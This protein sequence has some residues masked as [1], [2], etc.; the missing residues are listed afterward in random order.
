M[1][2]LAQTQLG[3]SPTTIGLLSQLGLRGTHDILWPS[4]PDTS[5]SASLVAGLGL[6]ERERLIDN[7]MDWAS[8]LESPDLEGRLPRECWIAYL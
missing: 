8:K 1:Q 6:G 7:L 3:R 2:Q 5:T 4:E